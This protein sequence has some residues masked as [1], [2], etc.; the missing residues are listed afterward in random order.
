MFTFEGEKVEYTLGF[1]YLEDAQELDKNENENGTRFS[2]NSPAADGTFW[3][4]YSKMD[5]S[6]HYMAVKKSTIEK[7]MMT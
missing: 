7:L 6:T 1:V 2:L 3:I 4:G 5:R